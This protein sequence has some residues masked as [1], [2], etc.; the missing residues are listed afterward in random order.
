MSR[1]FLLVSIPVMVRAH[2][3]NRTIFLDFRTSLNSPL[4]SGHSTRGTKDHFLI[5]NSLTKTGQQLHS[6][7]TWLGQTSK[8]QVAV[9]T[10]LQ[11]FRQEKQRNALV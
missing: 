3:S 11:V 5:Y 1:P 10:H 7:C 9:K 6:L 4:N 2:H 8:N